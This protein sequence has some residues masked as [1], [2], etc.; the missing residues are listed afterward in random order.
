M[1]SSTQSKTLN[2]G[3]S[4]T[5][6]IHKE[7]DGVYRIR[8]RQQRRNRSLRVHGPKELA[9]KI[10]RKKLSARD[11]NRHLDV[12]KEK[13]FRMS[14][15]IDRYW[16]QYGR[17]KKSSDREKS[18]LE[19]IRRELGMLFVREIDG[20]AIDRWYQS[21]IEEKGLSPGTAVRHFNVMH[22]MMGKAAA[23]WSKETGIDRN[24]AD[25]VEVK[26]SDDQR[27]RYR[28]HADP[29]CHLPWGAAATR[30]LAAAYSYRGAR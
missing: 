18:I 3:R 9:I 27:E 7:A 17:K 16:E 6:S 11:E 15:L 5:V 4:H 23:I 13:N 8:W 29:C 21:L 30:V 2:E 22:H 28:S 10:L 25:Q 19:G 20:S 14:A 24:P 1:S 26:R 12:K